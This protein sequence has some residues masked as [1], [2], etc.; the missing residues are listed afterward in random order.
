M[1]PQQVSAQLNACGVPVDIS[2]VHKWEVGEYGP[3]ERELFALADVLW[4]RTK[5]LMNIDEPRTLVEH[6]LAR[7]F[8]TAKLADSV[9]MDVV[10]YEQAEERNTWTGDGYQTAALLRL[11]NLTPFQ[12]AKAT[13]RPGGSV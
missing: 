7:Q 2:Q 4:C 10:Q 1:S 12:L 8:T 3:T 11:F 9:A 13:E 6:R 5:D